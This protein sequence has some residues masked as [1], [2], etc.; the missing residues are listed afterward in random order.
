MTGLIFSTVHGS[1]L[2]G[3]AHE[4]SDLDVYEVYEGKALKLRQSINDKDD[5]VR[6]TIEAFLIRATTGS[7]QSVEALFSQQK[8]WAPGMHEKYGPML[9]GLRITGGDVYAKYERTIKSFAHSEEVKKR[10]HAVRLSLNLTALRNHG[11]F[12]P[13]LTQMEATM[14]KAYGKTFI[15]NDLLE[16]L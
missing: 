14:C 11:R 9:E 4:D 10:V 7:H 5:S 15:G 16:L 3:L 2:Y 12:N 6:G 8:Q 1:H 13:T